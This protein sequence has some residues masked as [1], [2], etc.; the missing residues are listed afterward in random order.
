MLGNLGHLFIISAF[1]SIMVTIYAYVKSE[2][3]TDL[4]HKNSWCKL[5]RSSYWVHVAAVL[6]AIVSLYLIIYFQHFEYQYAWKHSS[7]T[8]PW[9]F[10]ISCFWEGQEGSFL[11]WIFWNALLGFII[12]RSSKSWEFTNM[13]VFCSIQFFLLSMIL[14]LY[15]GGGVKIGS[16]PFLL[17]RDVMEADIFNIDPDF[18]PSDGTGLN[19]LLQNIWMVI[20]PPIIFLGF[21]LSGVPFAFAISALWKNELSDFVRR[22]AP[23]LL[24]T[25]CVLGIGILMGAY[26]AYETL[27]FGGYWNWDPVENAVFV[28]WIIFIGALHGMVLYRRKE[29]GFFL[30]ISLTIGGFLLIVYSTFLTRSGILGN[31]SVHSFTDLGLSG[32][33]LLFLLFFVFAAIALLVYRKESL[34]EV[35]QNLSY[36]SLEFWMLLGICVIGLSAFQV[37]LPTSIPVLN[38]ILENIG[39]DRNF[40]PPVDP[41][42][43][44][45]KFQL[46]FAV[47]FCLLSAIAQTFY[48][49]KI[50]T[51]QQLENEM[52]FPLVFTLVVTSIFV[53][54]GK[55]RDF[56]Y[57]CLVASSLYLFFVSLFI[58][59]SLL[60]Q[61]Q[62][63]TIGGILAHVGLAV[64]LIGFVYSAGHQ[65][66]ISQNMAINMPGS[67][68]PAHS[69]QENMLLSRNVQK[70]NND[71]SIIYETKS[72]ESVYYGS[73]IPT[74]YTFP[75]QREDQKIIQES[76][77]DNEGNWIE[78][79]DTVIIN[80]ENTF[81]TI[82]VEEPGGGVFSISPRMQNNPQ[83]GYIASPDIKSYPFRDIYTHITNFP[84]PEKV[85]WNEPVNREVSLGEV[86]E[87]DG[88]RFK[89][90]AI[91][92]KD[93]VPGVPKMNNALALEASVSVIDNT[94]SYTAHPIFHVSADRS[95]RLFPDEI[96]SLGTKVLL[97]NV[98]P[99][100]DRYELTVITSQRDWI[101]IKSI[102]MP[103]ISLVWLGAL[104]MIGGVGMA[105]YNRLIE[106]K[107]SAA[108]DE[109]VMK[110]KV[111]H[112]VLGEKKW[113]VSSEEV[114]PVNI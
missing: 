99:V 98:S 5:A 76:F 84:D 37:L 25:V 41:I 73:L 89:I 28:P 38:V 72:Y 110:V 50:K 56:S 4:A 86:I 60:K 36:L 19:P 82:S 27:N 16:S 11:L 87:V 62:S 55:T 80:T 93:E 9:Y 26:W 57:I 83:M 101:T 44:Y 104:I 108:G 8:L 91:S 70:E 17:L 45:G 39:I 58:F 113:V 29:K 112:S 51:K 31:S 81:Y 90:D 111:D 1:V 95:V 107:E 52:I 69:V 34:S 18:I 23:S 40:A 109:W 32:Q 54:V 22:T 92:V 10:I 102:E 96:E 65:R 78:E 53:L 105:F 114:R 106:A 43:F 75:T 94:T 100:D 67:G 35:E 48:W 15:F 7:K 2:L 97:S 13:T 63:K 24:A 42:G 30:T 88:L 49:K 6:A 85:E 103:L 79:G 59:L 66:I 14:G 47:T 20:H 21:A 64:M 71:Y 74:D 46:W 61:F 68:L 33:L 77:Y 3:S 12:I